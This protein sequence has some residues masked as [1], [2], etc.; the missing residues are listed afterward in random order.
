MACFL[1]SFLPINILTNTL[2][3]YKHQFHIYYN[4]IQHLCSVSLFYSAFL[5]WKSSK[6]LASAKSCLFF[7]HITC[8]H[9]DSLSLCSSFFVICLR[10]PPSQNYARLLLPNRIVFVDTS[11]TFPFQVSNQLQ[12]NYPFS[13]VKCIFKLQSNLGYLFFDTPH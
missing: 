8:G 11:K 3:H 9:V 5:G 4:T 10:L 6:F 13:I 7:V 12:G 1:C 2:V